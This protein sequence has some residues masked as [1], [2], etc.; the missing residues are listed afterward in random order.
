MR[1][2]P[3][4]RLAMITS[5]RTFSVLNRPPPRY[6]GHIPL[7]HMERGALAIG[8][9]VISLFNPRRGGVC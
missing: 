6:A 1:L 5:S 9:A 8:S 2:P 4:A 3:A 7:T